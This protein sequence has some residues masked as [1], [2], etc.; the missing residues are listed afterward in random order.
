MTTATITLQQFEQIDGLFNACLYRP[1]LER[2]MAHPLASAE[3]LR[4]VYHRPEWKLF[5][6]C[7]EVIGLDA[8]QAFP[9]AIDC[10]AAILTDCLTGKVE[11]LDMEA[12]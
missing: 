2:V 5:D 11:V 6:A 12:A 7:V 8:A 3:Y 1:D 10:A 4:E 9:S